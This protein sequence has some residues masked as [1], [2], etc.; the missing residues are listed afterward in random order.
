MNLL[1]RIKNFILKKIFYKKTSSKEIIQ[2]KDEC[3]AIEENY[4]NELI[5]NLTVNDV[6]WVKMN[7]KDAMKTDH[8]ERPLVITRIFPQHRLLSGYYTTSNYDS[9]FVKSQYRIILSQK[10]YALKKDSLIENSKIV[11]VPFENVKRFMFHL[12]KDD[13]SKIKKYFLLRTHNPIRMNNKEIT[14]EINDIIEDESQKYIIYDI[15]NDNYYC[16]RLEAYNNSNKNEKCVKLDNDLYTIITDEIITVKRSKNYK[17]VN[18]VSE[19]QIIYSKIN[20]E[21]IPKITKKNNVK[22]LKIGDIILFNE[23]QY[24]IHQVDNTNGYGYEIEKAKKESNNK[25]EKLRQVSIN[26][27]IYTI[28]YEN[29]ITL[30]L[31]ETEYNKINRI[32]ENKVDEIKQNKKELKHLK[33]ANK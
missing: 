32:T 21:V 22:N 15:E 7:E 33:K 11:T 9:K 25:K 6:I 20:N 24:I 8:T 23:R 3:E 13:Q 29:N 17:I 10:V 14:P 28:L 5:K 19:E 2:E 27:E 1:K 16:Y 18:R 31:K 12:T 4:D 30:K 26:Q